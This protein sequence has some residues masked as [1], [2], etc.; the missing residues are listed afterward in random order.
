MDRQIKESVPWQTQ[1]KT[2]LTLGIKKKKKQGWPVS[3]I[4]SFK[5]TSQNVSTVSVPSHGPYTLGI[6]NRLRGKTESKLNR[7]IESPSHG[8]WA[9]FPQIL[10]WRE[11]KSRPSHEWK[12]F[13]LSRPQLEWRGFPH[14]RFTPCGGDFPLLKLLNIA[15]KTYPPATFHIVW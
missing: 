1:P 6:P 15:R 9:G 2:S 8:V 4:H 10:Y 11:E 3:Y 12:G 13:P 7:L 14:Y 5:V